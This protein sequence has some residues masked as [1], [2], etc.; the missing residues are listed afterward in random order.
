ML[1]KVVEPSNSKLS[2]NFVLNLFSK[3]LKCNNIKFQG[4]NYIQI[5]DTAMGTL[6]ALSF[7]NLFVGLLEESFLIFKNLYPLFWL[8]FIEDIFLTGQNGFESPCNFLW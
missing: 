8:G 2:T 7:A 5:K 3:I 4:Q 6:I 1:V